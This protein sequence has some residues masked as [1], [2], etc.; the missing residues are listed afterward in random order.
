MSYSFQCSLKNGFAPNPLQQGCVGYL[1]D[2]N[3]LGLS[4]PLAKDLTV[5]FP[6][7][8]PVPAYRPLSPVNGKVTVTAVLGDFSWNGGVG[9]PLVF[10][11]FMSSQNANQLQAL[12]QTTLKTTSISA[13]GW[14]IANYDQPTNKWYEIFYPKLPEK[15]SGLLNRQGANI[16][17][18][19]DNTPTQAAPGITVQAVSLAI[20]PPANQIVTFSLA[21]SP[22]VRE[23]KPWGIIVG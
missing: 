16:Q 8:S 12:K 20:A 23:V 3:G 19:V 15:P 14:W 9:D 17:L 2:F 1:T 10:T 21:S 4:G 7:D 11:C 5:S 13:F 18:S 6:Y 22:T